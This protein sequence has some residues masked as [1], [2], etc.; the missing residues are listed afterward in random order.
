MVDNY[1]LVACGKVG[2]IVEKKVYDKAEFKRVS[3]RI[4]LMKYRI[5]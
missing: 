4:L 5:D 2:F 3:D 1:R